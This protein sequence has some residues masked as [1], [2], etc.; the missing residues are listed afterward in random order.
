MLH[1]F[2]CCANRDR[3]YREREISPPKT[4]AKK[5]QISWHYIVTA[6]AVVVVLDAN[7]D[8]DAIALI[9][10]YGLSVN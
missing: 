4:K 6:A 8:V 2:C 9:H 5:E 7:A 1:T 10:Y 3:Y